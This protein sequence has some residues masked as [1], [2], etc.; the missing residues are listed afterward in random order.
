MWRKNFSGGQAMYDAWH[1]NFG[2]LLGPGSGAAGC[3]TRHLCGGDAVAADL[4]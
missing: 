4:Y 1:A 2:A 3:V